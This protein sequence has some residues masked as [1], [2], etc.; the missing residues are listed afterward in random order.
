M[1]PKGSRLHKIT[2]WHSWNINQQKPL[3]IERLTLTLHAATSSSYKSQTSSEKDFQDIGGLDIPLVNRQQGPFFLR[4]T[5]LDYF[6]HSQ[7]PAQ[8]PPIS[9]F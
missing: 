7:R 3:G 9:K 5:A 2:N 1:L 4:E 6:L 8:G